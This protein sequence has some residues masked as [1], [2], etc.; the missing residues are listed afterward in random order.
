MEGE[1]SKRNVLHKEARERC[2]MLTTTSGVR[3]GKAEDTTRTKVDTVACG[4]EL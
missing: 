1:G 2:T 3:Y 4:I